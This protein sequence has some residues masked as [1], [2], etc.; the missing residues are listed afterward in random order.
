FLYRNGKDLILVNVET[1]DAETLQGIVAGVQDEFEWSPDGQF[2]VIRAAANSEIWPNSPYCLNIYR[3]A[4]RKILFD[5]PLACEIDAVGMSHDSAQIGYA[6][7][8]SDGL[9]AVLW[10]YSLSDGKTARVY[11]TTDGSINYEASITDIRWS[12]KDHYAS[13][14]ASKQILGGSTNDLH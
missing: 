14:V 5:K 7:R 11:E 13:F 3:M 12:P 8:T 2:I 10:I 9:N 6:T 4:E 1:G